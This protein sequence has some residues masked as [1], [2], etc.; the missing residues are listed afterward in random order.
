[1]G[2][3]GSQGRRLLFA[4]MVRR[5]TTNIAIRIDQ[6]TLEEF[7]GDRFV[8]INAWNEWAEGCHLEPCRMYGKR[9][10]RRRS[11]PS[12]A[13]QNSIHSPRRNTG[14]VAREAATAFAEDAAAWVLRH[15]KTQAQNWRWT[16]RDGQAPS[17]H[18]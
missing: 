4:L 8:F 13:G 12:T 17:K 14:R 1:M 18:D 15:L 11:T 10:L 6:R 7:P 2:Q 9:F 3:H 16:A 5:K